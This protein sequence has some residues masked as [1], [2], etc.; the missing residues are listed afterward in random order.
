L[1]PTTPRSE[2]LFIDYLGAE[3]NEYTRAVAKKWLAAAVTRIYRPGCKF[4][5]IPVVL[6]EQGQKKSMLA[7]KLGGRWYSDSFTTVQGKESFEQLQGAWII[8]IPELSG[9]RKAESEAIKHYIS[10]RE[11]RYRVAYGRRVENFPRQSVFMATGNIEE[12]IRD[13]TGGRRFWPVPTYFQEP[14][15]DIATDLDDERDQI[16]AEAME[17]YRKGEPLYLN[18]EL[19]LV[20]KEVQKQHSEQD[21]RAGLVQEYLETLLP[22]DWKSRDVYQRR[23]WLRS[24][25]EL[26]PAGELARDKVC[27]PEIW[28]EVLGGLQ[29]DMNR[30]NVKDLHDI[31]RKM[32]GWKRYNGKMRFG[33]YGIQQGYVKV[34]K[35]DLYNSNSTATLTATKKR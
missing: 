3:D 14:I 11:D 25:D 20:A 34:L 33:I 31:M 12:F 15:M 26:Q 7:D 22:N 16:W 23:E 6:G 32:D 18:K 17:Y 29:K 19:E 10:K 13:A 5:Y 8:E 2:N 30:H 35:S 1:T 9:F 27:I 28:C 4:D 21:D 24:E